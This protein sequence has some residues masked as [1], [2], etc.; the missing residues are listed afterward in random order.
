VS[1]HDIGMRHGTDKAT[2]HN[3]LNF[4]EQHI[5]RDKVQ[6]L[7]EIGIF[8][9]ASIRTWRE[10][11]PDS[12]IVEGWDINPHATI[13]GCDLRVVDQLDVAAMTENITGTYD[14]IVDDGGH[15]ARMM[16]TSFATL[17]PHARLYII[18]DLHAPW[19]G[20]QYLEPG[21]VNTLTM[22]E[23]FH[24]NG[25]VSPYCS[26][27]QRAYINANA[28]IEGLMITRKDNELSSATCVIR[29]KELHV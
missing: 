8:Q 26:E 13:E 23:D 16:Q 18:E 20:G 3:F 21:D 19:C 29:N 22:L 7:L 24:I 10:W 14:V 25:W 5:D 15:T 4:Y 27:Q 17:F 12:A 2:Y 11:L 1:L 28:E 9:G 6:R